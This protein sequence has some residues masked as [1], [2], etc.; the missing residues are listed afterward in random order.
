MN[1]IFLY[2]L[3]SPLL[4]KFHHQTILTYSLVIKEKL[5][6]H[7]FFFHKLTLGAHLKNEMHDNYHILQPYHLYYHG[8]QMFLDWK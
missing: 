4:S 2:V 5:S 6:K 8:Q 1:Y 7:I 3:K